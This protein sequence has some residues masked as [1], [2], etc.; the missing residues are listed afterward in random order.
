MIACYGNMSWQ[1][2]NSMNCIVCAFE[3]SKGVGVWFGAPSMKRMYGMSLAWHWH[4]VCVHVHSM[5]HSKTVCSCLLLLR[6]YAFPS[7][8]NTLCVYTNYVFSLCAKR[9]CY[10]FYI[11]NIQVIFLPSKIVSIPYCPNYQ[12]HI[13]W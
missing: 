9:H 5:S 6:V 13:C 10:I 11:S 2:V 12:F 4:F 1:Y 3:G 8:L 7:F